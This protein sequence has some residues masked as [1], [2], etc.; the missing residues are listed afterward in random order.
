[1]VDSIGT[2]ATL[3]PSLTTHSTSSQFLQKNPGERRQLFR[4]FELWGGTDQCRSVS[5]VTQTLFPGESHVG[6]SVLYSNRQ[7]TT[8]T[9]LFDIHLTPTCQIYNRTLIGTSRSTVPPSKSP[10]YINSDGTPILQPIPDVGM[11]DGNLHVFFQSE[12][13]LLHFRSIGWK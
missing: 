9:V 4:V 10:R 12:R 6:S 7:H 11:P 1:M 3:L 2:L 13:S 8:N 5:A